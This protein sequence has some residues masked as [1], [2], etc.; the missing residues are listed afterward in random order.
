MFGAY[1]TARRALRRT[2]GHRRNL[3]VLFALPIAGL[4]NAGYI[5]VM[6]G[7]YIHGRLLVAPLLATCAPVAVV[8]A[9]RRF[10]I[11]FLI[12]PWALL[13]GFTMRTTDGSP[14][15]TSTITNSADGDGLMANASTWAAQAPF[16]RPSNLTGA[17][18]QFDVAQ[19]PV[20]LDGAR[21]VA[22]PRS[23]WSPPPRSART[24]I[25][26]APMSGSSTSSDWPTP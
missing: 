20:R 11:S 17:W 23:R 24:R 21:D 12:V 7:D 10:V 4:L 25:C 6:G 13:C 18:V 16:S 8:P 2:I 3:A 5:V 14:F 26:S 19:P 15:S 9:T 1:R 22:A